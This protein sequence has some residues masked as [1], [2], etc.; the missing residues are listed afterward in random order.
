MSD[1]VTETH[2]LLCWSTHNGSGPGYATCYVYNALLALHNAAYNNGR[3]KTEQQ[4]NG[5]QLAINLI[6]SMTQI[7]DHS[8]HMTKR[9]NEIAEPHVR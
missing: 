3:E 1:R 8:E 5:M 6:E 2:D 4:V 7:P 9:I